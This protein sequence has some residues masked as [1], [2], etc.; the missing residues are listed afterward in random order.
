[1]KAE[2]FCVRR[3]FQAFFALLAA[4]TLAVAPAAASSAMRGCAEMSSSATMPVMAAMPAHVGKPAPCPT[5]T[6]ACGALCV[7]A[8]TPVDVPAPARTHLRIASTFRAVV[9]R[10]ADINGTSP[11][12]LH[13]PP[14]P[15]V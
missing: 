9:T 7:A 6:K 5:P 14:R 1:M 15:S 4:L 13:R 11:E 2:R 3:A 12:L 10:T 8:M